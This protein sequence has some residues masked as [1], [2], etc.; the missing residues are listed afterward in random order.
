MSVSSNPGTG[1][2]CDASK[3]SLTM[4]RTLRDG[5]EIFSL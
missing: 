3:I 1:F 4:G 2:H 5:R